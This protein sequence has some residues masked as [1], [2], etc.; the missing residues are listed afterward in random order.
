MFIRRSDKRK[1]G[2]S[3]C[4]WALVA[5]YRTER[6]VRQ[7]IVG[8]IGDVT[9]RQ[10]RQYKQLVERCD[11]IQQDFFSPEALPEIAL[12]ETRKTHTE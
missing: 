6:G 4:Y 5:S 2:R 9:G 11:S 12:I 3:H 8:Y 1:S 10:A 7:R